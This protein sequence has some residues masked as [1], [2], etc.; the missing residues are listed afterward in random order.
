MAYQQLLVRLCFHQTETVNT[1]THF[2]RKTAI[3]GG[4]M[5]IAD[6][7]VTVLLAVVV[8]PCKNLYKFRTLYMCT[9]V[10]S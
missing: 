9:H 7:A 6:V 1:G 10:Y 3:A 8:I 4:S 5:G 2:N